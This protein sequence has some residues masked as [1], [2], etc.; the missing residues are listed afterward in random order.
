MIEKIVLDYLSEN[1]DVPVFMETPVHVPQKYVLIE[2]VAGGI[3][4]HIRSANFIIQSYSTK[5]L[6]EASGLNDDVQAVMDVMAAY[7]P[8]VSECSMIADTNFTDTRTKRYRYQCIYS[9]YY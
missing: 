2:K 5:S 7:I 4:N 8:N 1:I 3:V 6:L 9:I